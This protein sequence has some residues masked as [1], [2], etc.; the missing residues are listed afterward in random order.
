M[1]LHKGKLRSIHTPVD[2]LSMH[3][4]VSAEPVP[5]DAPVIVLVHG[6]VV[7]SRYMVPSQLAV[8]PGAAHTINYSAPPELVRV[9]RAF[10]NATKPGLK[11]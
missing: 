2:G 3:A 1:S 4:R 5:D 11:L 7:S 9:T 6:L 10:L 8:I